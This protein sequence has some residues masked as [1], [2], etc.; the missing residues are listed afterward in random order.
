MAKIN[1][2]ATVRAVLMR[3][4]QL[5]YRLAHLARALCMCAFLC[6]LVLVCFAVLN[7]GPVLGLSIVAVITT[8][9]CTPLYVLTTALILVLRPKQNRMVM[10]SI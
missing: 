10:F 1:D 2:F 9:I 4:Q 5:S 6:V 8:L 7:A 3:R